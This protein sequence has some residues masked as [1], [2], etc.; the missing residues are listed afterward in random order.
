MVT[1][2]EFIVVVTQNYWFQ[3]IVTEKLFIVPHLL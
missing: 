2:N 3:N 1:Q